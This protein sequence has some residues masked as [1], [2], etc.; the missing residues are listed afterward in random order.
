M[1][2]PEIAGWEL[3]TNEN[4]I[5]MAILPAIQLRDA[6]SYIEHLEQ[7][8]NSSGISD[9]PSDEQIN[10]WVQWIDKR[11]NFTDHQKDYV[12]FG[13]KQIFKATSSQDTPEQTG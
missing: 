6:L 4:G 5:E 11:C 1:N 12:H 2:K 7:K 10:D 3:T 9:K 13:I 8:L